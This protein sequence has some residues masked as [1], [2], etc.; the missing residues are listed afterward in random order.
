MGK[1][2]HLPRTVATMLL[3][4]QFIFNGVGGEGNALKFPQ[5][6]KLLKFYSSE[7]FPIEASIG[8]SKVGK[9]NFLRMWVHNDK[10]KRRAAL[11]SSHEQT[12]LGQVGF[13]LLFGSRKL[14]ILLLSNFRGS[15]KAFSFSDSFFFP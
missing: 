5:T 6:L 14:Q 2:W 7:F 10:H 1:F 13:L 15:D 11:G 8:S 12:A 3:L 4:K 9:W